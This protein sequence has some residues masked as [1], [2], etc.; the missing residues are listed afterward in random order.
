[1]AVQA[2]TYGYKPTKA[3]QLTIDTITKY[4]PDFSG[5]VIVV[6]KYGDYGA[7]C[8]GFDRFPYSIANAEHNKVSILYITCSKSKSYNIW[9]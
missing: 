9:P 6:N 8:H 4:Y 2:M 7:A 1:M 3:A 5:A